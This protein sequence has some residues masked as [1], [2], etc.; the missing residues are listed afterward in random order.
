ML[1]LLSV[2]ILR[3]CG[4][5]H[6]CFSEAAGKNPKEHKPHA[7]NRPSRLHSTSLHSGSF[8]YRWL[9]NSLFFSFLSLYPLSLS[10]SLSLSP[11]RCENFQCN[12]VRVKAR[13][14]L[15]IIA[16]CNWRLWR[17][18]ADGFGYSDMLYFHHDIFILMLLILSAVKIVVS[19][20]KVHWFS[21]ALLWV[22]ITKVKF[23]KERNKIKF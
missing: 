13:L 23:Y 10:L 18:R 20:L 2:F 21:S 17:T 7:N 11:P 6:L 16:D 5:L 19:L 22:F 4:H 3:G 12:S 9:F 15:E 8:P 14:A 1:K